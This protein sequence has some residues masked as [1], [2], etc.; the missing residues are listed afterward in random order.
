L[1][2]VLIP[3]AAVVLVGDAPSAAILLTLAGR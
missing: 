1:G 3:S 2:L